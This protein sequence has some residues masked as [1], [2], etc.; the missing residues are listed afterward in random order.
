MDVRTL[1]GFETETPPGNVITG[2]GVERPLR[3]GPGQRVRSAG[4]PWA[5]DR[6]PATRS[7]AL[8]G[9]A[10]LRVVMTAAVASPSML[11]M[12]DTVLVPRGARTAAM[13]PTVD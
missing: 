13:G 5:R 4:S 3:R 9:K 8:H 1:T 7:V 10:E 2:R 12:A 6:R 11:V